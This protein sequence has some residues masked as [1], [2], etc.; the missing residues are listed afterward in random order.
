LRNFSE[1]KITFKIDYLLIVA[2]MILLVNKFLA[3]VPNW[4]IYLA[5]IMVIWSVAWL[6]LSLI[7]LL[8]KKV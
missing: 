1:E 3:E 8:A 5:W 7:I 6:A 4:V 2:V